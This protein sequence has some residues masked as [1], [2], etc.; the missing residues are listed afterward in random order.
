MNFDYRPENP[1]ISKPS[2]SIIENISIF[3]YTKMIRFCLNA[4]F[5]H[6]K[7]F[8][9]FCTIIA[10]VLFLF[11]IDDEIEKLKRW[12]LIYKWK[13]T[14]L[15][16]KLHRL[17]LNKTNTH[18]LKCILDLFY[19][20][21]LELNIKKCEFILLQEKTMKLMFALILHFMIYSLAT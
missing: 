21:A 13:H 8:F 12:S 17:H 9:A 19:L 1:S 2:T 14:P 15:Y 3:S 20:T 16:S 18:M 6:F 4:T 10:C 7:R 11:V 5:F